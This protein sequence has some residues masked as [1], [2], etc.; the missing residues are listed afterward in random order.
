MKTALKKVYE[1]LPLKKEA[2][3]LMKMFWTPDQNIYRHLHFHGVFRVDI[4]GAH[5]F[6]INHHGYQIENEIF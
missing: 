2:F 3:T 1:T 6:Q 4:D 5:S